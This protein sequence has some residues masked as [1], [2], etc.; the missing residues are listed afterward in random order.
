MSHLELTL[1]TPVLVLEDDPVMQRR[2]SY[3]LLSVG[4]SLD[5]VFF[6]TTI[7]DAKVMFGQ[8][9]IGFCIVDLGLPDG[10]GRELI[11]YVRCSNTQ[12]PI[13]VISAWN[14]QSDILSAIQAGAT[15]YLLKERDDFE[16]TLLLRSIFKGGSPIDPFVAQQ[17]LSQIE[18]TPA[19]QVPL[20]EQE[21]LLSSREL[22]ILEWVAKGLTNKAIAKQ[23]NLSSH[24]V[25]SH[26]QH[27]YRKLSVCTR[28]K[29]I[30]TARTLGIL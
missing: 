3:L 18:F 6:S 23:L 16:L 24:T 17:I 29:A 5:T 14:T 20:A 15:G 4:Y 19:E 10:H 2:L 11:Q 13:L 25:N 22:E 28:T 27:I 21:L 12:I 30:D 8:H 26:I 9:E 1:P 7:A